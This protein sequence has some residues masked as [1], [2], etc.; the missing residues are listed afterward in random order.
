MTY[1]Y[2]PRFYH[3]LSVKEAM[4]AKTNY[5]HLVS[6]T[7]YPLLYLLYQ[8]TETPVTI[9]HHAHTLI[10]KNSCTFLNGLVNF[11]QNFVRINH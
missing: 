7:E 9:G 6:I 10:G 11:S 8:L 2:I 4:K 5:Q 3:P 1:S